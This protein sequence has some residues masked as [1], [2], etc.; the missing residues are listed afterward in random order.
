[1]YNTDGSIP[2]FIL[3]YILLLKNEYWKVSKKGFNYN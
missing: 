2:V 1:L 3:L